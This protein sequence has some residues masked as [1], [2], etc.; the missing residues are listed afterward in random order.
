MLH[1]A[2]RLE[3]VRHVKGAIGGGK[4]VCRGYCHTPSSRLCRIVCRPLFSAG[5]P[6][7][8]LFYPSELQDGGHRSSGV[9]ARCARS[10]YASSH[11]CLPL[12]CPRFFLSFFLSRVS[13]RLPIGIQRLP[14]NGA[15]LG[16]G[17]QSGGNFEFFPR[18]RHCCVGIIWLAGSMCDILHARVLGDGFRSARLGGEKFGTLSK[19]AKT[20]SKDEI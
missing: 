18:S 14:A 11:R 6:F 12:P 1:S 19:E 3:H 2:L 5:Y 10:R 20:K 4:A 15:E 9:S 13:F 17:E 8:V 7:F 16:T